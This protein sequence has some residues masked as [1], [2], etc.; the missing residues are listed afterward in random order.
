VE[1]YAALARR[2]QA[3]TDWEATPG[4]Y[5]RFCRWRPQCPEG[6]AAG[7]ARSSSGMEEEYGVEEE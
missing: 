4:V 2:I 5:C 6:Q 1:Q 3:N 7:E